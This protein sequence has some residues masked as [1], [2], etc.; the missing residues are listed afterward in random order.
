MGTDRQPLDPEFD[1]IVL[2]RA[3]ADL[4]DE[5]ASICQELEDV[6]VVLDRR[7][8]SGEYGFLRPRPGETGIAREI[9]DA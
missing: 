1:A 4:Y 7:Q 3:C 8:G 9:P 5:V 2:S 6:A